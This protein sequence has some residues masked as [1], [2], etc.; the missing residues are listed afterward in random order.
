MGLNSVARA[1]AGLVLAFAVPIAAASGME[2]IGRN[3][4]ARSLTSER[5]RAELPKGERAAW[6]AYLRK[7]EARMRADRA[8]LAA[9]KPGATPPPPPIAASQSTNY[10][11]MDR[12]AGWYGSAEALRIA[13][14]IVS[15]QTPAG[16]WSKNQDRTRPPRLPGQRFANDAETMNPDPRN[17]DAPRDRFWTFVGTFDNDATTGEMKF[18]A[19]VIAQKPGPDGDKYR[20]S[21][22]KGVRYMLEAQ[23]PNGGWPQIYPIEG[24]FHDGVTFNDNVV[25]SVVSLLNEVARGLYPYVPAQ[26]RLQAR[27][28]VQRGIRVILAA[29]VRKDGKLL[30]WPQQADPLT[31]TPIS[32]RNYEPRSIASAETAE[33]LLFLMAQPNPTSTMKKAIE[34]GITWLR[35]SAIY[36]QTWGTVAGRGRIL[37]PEKD[38]GPIWSRNYSLT[39]GKPIFGDVDQS[40]HDDVNLLS[41]GRRNGYSW[42]LTT[43]ER[44]L[45][46]YPDWARATSTP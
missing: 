4:P 37:R 7:S 21:F 42:Y 24:G 36:D 43:P 14:N 23:Y 8:A 17:F 35:K 18:L 3:V 13:D 38:A 29:Q 19:R 10:M 20:A 34:G 16:G 1:F 45:K 33:I 11:P 15:F 41:A 27:D 44:A 31:L 12:D 46:V 39:T 25:T 32:A 9:E 30:G 26:L 28:A 6:L 40:I 5:V 2:Q 22:A